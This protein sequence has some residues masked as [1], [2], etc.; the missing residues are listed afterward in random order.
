M[1]FSDNKDGWECAEIDF[2]VDALLILETE[3]SDLIITINHNFYYTT[4]TNYS[5]VEFAAIIYKG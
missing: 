5:I 1:L 3:T 4:L 2:L